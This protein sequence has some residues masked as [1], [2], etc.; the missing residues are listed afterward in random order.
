[1]PLK[2]RRTPQEKKALSYKKDRRNAYGESD[3]GARIAI[4]QNK[5]RENRRRRKATKQ[6]LSIL[7]RLHESVAEQI[8]SSLISGVER[9]GGWRKMRDLPLGEHLQHKL[10]KRAASVDAKKRRRERHVATLN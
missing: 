5:A 4:P 10:D 6:P 7:S 9:K 1:M 3:K 8:E 2:K